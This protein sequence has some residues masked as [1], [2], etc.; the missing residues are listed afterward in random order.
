MCSSAPYSTASRSQSAG[1]RIMQVQTDI[2]RESKFV[3]PQR[4]IRAY[5][6]GL[7]YVTWEDTTY[8]ISISGNSRS[9]PRHL[10][11]ARS[12]GI[13][14]FVYHPVAPPMLHRL[15]SPPQPAS[16]RDAYRPIVQTLRKAEP[17]PRIERAHP[18]HH[19]S[20]KSSKERAIYPTSAEL[21]PNHVR[22]CAACG[23]HGGKQRSIPCHTPH[24]E[25]LAYPCLFAAS[26]LIRSILSQSHTLADSQLR[27]PCLS[28]HPC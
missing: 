19:E 15:Q 7:S 20:A 4:M 27:C 25:A 8:P 3:Q 5:P 21:K 17:P 18:P 2:P 28:A 1:P 11:P 14:S 16:P 23:V 13:S 6:E 24:V 26:S 9:V 22:R 10:T 12:S